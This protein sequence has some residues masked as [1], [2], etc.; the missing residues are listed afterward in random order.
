MW[1]WRVLFG[2]TCSFGGGTKG[3]KSSATGR[4]AAVAVRE[5]DAVWLWAAAARE[6]VSADD[7]AAALRLSLFAGNADT[8]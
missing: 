3:G 2:Y 5:V 8:A 7:A 6:A 4:A 1:A